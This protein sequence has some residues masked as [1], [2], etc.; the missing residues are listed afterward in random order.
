MYY[1]S[2]HSNIIKMKIKWISD[3]DLLSVTP[4]T[5]ENRSAAEQI[6]REIQTSIKTGGQHVLAAVDIDDH[7]AEITIIPA[8]ET[9]P[10][11]SEQPN[12]RT[13]C[14]WSHYWEDRAKGM[15]GYE[16]CFDGDI[17]LREYEKGTLS[18]WFGPEVK[19][20]SALLNWPAYILYHA[21]TSSL[22]HPYDIDPIH[23]TVNTRFL[24]DMR[25]AYD[26]ED[27]SRKDRW[28]ITSEGKGTEP[29][30][31]LR[32]IGCRDALT[33]DVCNEMP[34]V[35]TRTFGPG[36]PTKAGR[37]Q[38]FVGDS[39]EDGKEVVEIDGDD[40]E[41][42]L[43][44]LPNAS[45]QS[46]YNDAEKDFKGLRDNIALFLR[47][48]RGLRSV[49]RPSFDKALKGL[50]SVDYVWLIKALIAA[51]RLT[52][53]V[54]DTGSFAKDEIP[55][56][57]CASFRNRLKDLSV[58]DG[59][60][61]VSVTDEAGGEWTRA[62]TGLEREDFR[63]LL[64]STYYQFLQKDEPDLEDWLRKTMENGKRKNRR[65]EGFVR[66]LIGKY[67]KT[68]NC[69]GNP[70]EKHLSLFPENLHFKDA[71]GRLLPV[72]EIKLE[73]GEKET[74]KVTAFSILLHRMFTTTLRRLSPVEAEAVT[75]LVFDKLYE[76]AERVIDDVDE[77]RD[78]TGDPLADAGINIRKIVSEDGFDAEMAILDSDRRD[79]YDERYDDDIED[80]IFEKM[81][82]NAYDFFNDPVLLAVWHNK[83][84]LN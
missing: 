56:L 61:V 72:S 4:D 55:S 31:T 10:T 39:L 81:K 24:T 70:C 32:H 33:G 73:M 67:G 80:D 58:R 2:I 8:D 15:V 21:V 51:R 7:E 27:E 75:A 44:I 41:T 42:L 17:N 78:S 13:E 20:T 18:K 48:R 16:T 43:A 83:W 1:G 59:R 69:S 11:R 57:R 64:V 52:H 23:Y 14:G 5:K 34:T 37:M 74:V 49:G 38:V 6:I 63:G 26:C 50:S 71:L 36:H 76:E 53:V 84:K 29:D 12:Y 54:Y 25:Y 68:I 40:I 82:R 77:I 28:E 79:A 3:G 46:P 22:I 30:T 60:L 62:L 19:K 47:K 66:S 9:V 35:T 65:R 45:E